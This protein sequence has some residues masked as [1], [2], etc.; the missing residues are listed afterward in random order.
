MDPLLFIIACIDYNHAWITTSFVL[1]ND[2][3]FE[4]ET[5]FPLSNGLRT[6]FK[7]PAASIG[8]DKNKICPFLEKKFKTVMEFAE[9]EDIQQARSNNFKAC[10]LQVLSDERIHEPLLSDDPTLDKKEQAYLDSLV[11][12]VSDFIVSLFWRYLPIPLTSLSLVLDIDEGRYK[13]VSESDPSFKR[14]VARFTLDFTSIAI[15]DYFAFFKERTYMPIFQVSARYHTI[16]ESK[17]LIVNWFKFQFG[18]N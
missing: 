2:I 17:V 12:P 13:Y 7:L 14:A 16:E 8:D 15:V 4:F 18:A 1:I 6:K 3:K 5:L 11:D 9:C 10:A